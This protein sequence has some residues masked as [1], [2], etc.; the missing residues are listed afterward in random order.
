MVHAFN[1]FNFY[2]DDIL[3]KIK[4]IINENLAHPPL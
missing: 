3:H 4:L 1:I 2:S